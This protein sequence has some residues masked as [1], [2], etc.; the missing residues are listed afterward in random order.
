M[1][2]G[3]QTKSIQGLAVTSVSLEPADAYDLL[4]ELAPVIAGLLRAREAVKEQFKT[5]QTAL[6]A[7]EKGGEE[8]AAAANIEISGDA[9]A[10]ALTSAGQALGGGKLTELL[11]RLLRNTEFKGPDGTRFRIT[12]RASFSLAF[13]DRMWAA[14]PM[15]AFAFEVTFGNFS[16]VVALLPGV[17]RRSVAAP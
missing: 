12:D 6:E 1:A 9:I 2:T 4:P 7:I 17:K 10:A 3:P 15:A 5:L 16:D 13:S 11:V 8:A 14:I